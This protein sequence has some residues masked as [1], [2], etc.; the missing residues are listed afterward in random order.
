[1]AVIQHPSPRTSLQEFLRAVTQTQPSSA[2]SSK[3]FLPSEVRFTAAVGSGFY[4]SDQW[5][6]YW[7]LGEAPHPGVNTE[8]GLTPER[9]ENKNSDSNGQSCP[10]PISILI[11]YLEASTTFTAMGCSPS[12]PETDGIQPPRCQN[13]R[14]IRC[15]SIGNLIHTE[16]WERDR[17]EEGN[18]M[19][20]WVLVLTA[21][22]ASDVTGAN[23]SLEEE[24]RVL[25]Q[26]RCV[27]GWYKYPRLNNCYRYFPRARTWA[28]AEVF[29]KRQPHSGHLATVTSLIHNNFILE[30]IRAS[31]KP[32]RHVWIGLNNKAKGGSFTWIDGSSSKYRRCDA[33]EGNR[34]RRCW[35]IRR[36]G[37]WRSIRCGHRR[38]FVCTYRL[39]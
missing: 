14:Y 1:M 15:G 32:K 11:I 8:L 4:R 23:N 34:R 20:V 5:V 16:S 26:G 12:G 24:T 27:K 25:S 13:Y 18:M 30:V 36:N 9:F 28:S 21:L 19:L 38:P 3:T 29:C 22:L 39:H 31:C 35:L 7:D 37:S 17:F 33:D 10:F 6:K 2:D